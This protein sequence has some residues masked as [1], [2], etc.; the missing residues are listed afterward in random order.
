MIVGRGPLQRTFVLHTDLFTKQS[1]FFRAARSPQWLSTSADPTKPVDCE[2]DDPDVFSAYV[3]CAYRGAEG[4]KPDVEDQTPH[5]A[6][7]ALVDAS[8]DPGLSDL[9]TYVDHQAAVGDEQPQETSGDTQADVIPS[10]RSLGRRKNVKDVAQAV[11]KYWVPTNWP[12]AIICS[13]WLRYT[14]KPTNCKTLRLP[15]RS[16]TDSSGSPR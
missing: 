2:D 3:N 4:I 14:C 1:E 16:W 6:D 13:I 9:A 12:C 10:M 5:P 11:T 8:G 7:L 15:T